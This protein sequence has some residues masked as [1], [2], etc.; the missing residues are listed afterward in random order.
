MLSLCHPVCHC[1]TPLCSGLQGLEKGTDLPFPGLGC[2]LQLMSV[3]SARVRSPC[4][5]CPGH[6]EEE[7]RRCTAPWLCCRG[8]SP[9]AQGA[10]LELSKPQGWAE[11]GEQ[12]VLTAP[13]LQGCITAPVAAPGPCL[14][15]TLPVSFLCKQLNKL[16][17]DRQARVWVQWRWGQMGSWASHPAG[18]YPMAHTELQTA[19]RKRI[20][21]S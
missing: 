6:E 16:F 17:G 8:W 11:V 3:G 13:S 20:K 4:A 18:I 14:L 9:L 10:C 2:C 12:P 1:C 7:E 21:R 5:A 15:L 19:Q